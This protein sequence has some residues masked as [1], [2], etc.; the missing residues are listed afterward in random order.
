MRGCG[1]V[2]IYIKNNCVFGGMDD[3]KACNL[4]DVK[5]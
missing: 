1:G 3:G 2:I 5:G 4:M